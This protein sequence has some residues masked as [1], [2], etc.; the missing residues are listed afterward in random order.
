MKKIIVKE[1]FSVYEK[2]KRIERLEAHGL[3]RRR[4]TDCMRDKSL[5]FDG[6]LL[7]LEHTLISGENKQAV[8]N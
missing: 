2:A 6:A 8:Y 7:F 4:I 3:H 1:H 5:S